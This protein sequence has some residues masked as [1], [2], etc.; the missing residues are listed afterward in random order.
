[1]ITLY[2][3]WRSSASRRVRL[4]L[5]E[6]GL[7]Y[8]GHIVDM[9]KMEHHSPEYLKINP[10]GVIPTLIHDGR[11][12]HESGTICEYL[13]ETYPDP[14]LRPQ[15]PYER[16][17]MRNWIRHIDGL[18]GNLIVFN[19]RH[20]LAK[21]AAQWSDDELAAKLKSIPSKERQE[22]W[23]RA[24]RNPYTEEERAAARAKL[25]VLLDKMEDAMQRSGWLVGEAYSLADIAAAPFVKRIDEEIAPDEVTATKHPRVAEWWTSLQERPAFK[26]AEFGPFATS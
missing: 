22:A 9:A 1:M 8:D 16:A 5:E 12:L 17:E 18:I 14:P 20:H 19:W 25:V 4:C 15:T 13:D 2:H 10:L 23:L 11:P 7:A 21:V 24:A 3:G 6:K 26:R